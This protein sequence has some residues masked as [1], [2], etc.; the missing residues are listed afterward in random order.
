MKLQEKLNRLKEII[1]GYKSCVIA[2]SG[3]V[4]STL[5]IRVAK[6]ILPKNKILAVTAVSLTYP[7]EELRFSKVIAKELGVRHKIIK[8]EEFKDKKFISNPINRCYFCK[9]ELFSK[10]KKIAAKNKLNF[11]LD[12]SNISDESDFRP[13]DKAKD[14]LKV[15]SPLLEAGFNKEDIRTLSKLLGLRTWNKQSLACLASRIPYGTEISS[16]VLKRIN[17]AEAYLRNIGFSQVRVRHYDGLCRIE[18][19]KE[20]TLRLTHLGNQIVDRFKALG[21]NYV[22]VDLEGYRTGSMNHAL[23]KQLR[24]KFTGKAGHMKL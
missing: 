14:E 10:L 17:Q 12:A 6:G 3:G 1:S 11:V 15:C 7:K 16:E 4:D 13:G 21:Y 20:D 5:L 23:P 9:K 19:L 22:T 2:F 8:T 24:D 18:V